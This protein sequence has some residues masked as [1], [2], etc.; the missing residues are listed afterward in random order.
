MKFVDE[1]IIDVAAGDG[2]NGCASMRHEKFREFGVVEAT[3][4]LGTHTG[5]L[6]RVQRDVLV[7]CGVG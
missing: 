7:T 1:A 3:L 4:Q 2:G 6:L 5:K